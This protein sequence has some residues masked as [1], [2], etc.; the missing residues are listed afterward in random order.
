M[1]WMKGM[2]LLLAANILIMVTLSLTVPL[3]INIILPMFGIDLRGSVDLSSL[4]WALVFGFGGAFIS[5]AFSKQMARAMLDCRQITQPRS[6]AEQV[7]YGAV[8]EIAQRLHI[9]MPEVWVYES[10]DPNA[11]ATGPSKN[12]S[13]VAVSTGLLSNLQE[14]EVRAVLAHEMGHVYNGD[15]FA[16]TVL[17]G[18]MNTFVYYIAMWVRRFF[19]D[20]DQAALGFGLSIALQ[21]IISI[22]ASVLISWFSR[23]REY[24]ADAFSAK[25]YG[26]DS[27][28]S[29]L[30]AID[31][32]V[33]R[34]QIEYSSQ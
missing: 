29:A 13:M 25:V 3:L 15:M 26:K 19:E 8:Q 10:P 16:T 6:Q 28:I 27:M 30:R 34:S 23:H 11:F 20:R 14:Q 7:V 22:L 12:N 21:I 2:F 32:W 9:T 18:L 17:M 31:R 1:K 4:V 33:T 5:L 24:G